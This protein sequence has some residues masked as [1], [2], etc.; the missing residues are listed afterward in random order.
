MSYN[1]CPV[2]GGRLTEDEH[3]V[4]SCDTCPYYWQ[5]GDTGQEAI[6]RAEK[7]LDK[8]VV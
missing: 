2:C 5:P 4:I 1:P 7:E 3:E 6:E 8:E